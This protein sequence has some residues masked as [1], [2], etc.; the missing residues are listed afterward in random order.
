MT[1]KK[2]SWIELALQWQG[3]VAPKVL[4]G[5]L[6]CGG[7]GFFVSI[8]DYFGLPIAWPG[9]EVVISNVSYNLVLGLLLVFRTNTAYERFWE[10]RKAWATFTANI[11]NLGYLMWAAITEVEPT[12]R[13]TKVLTLRLLST[14]AFAAKLHLQRQPI[15][16]ESARLTSNQ[17]LKLKTVNGPPLQLAVWIGDYFQQQHQRNLLTT[18]QLTMMNDLVNGLLE[19]LTTCERILET[20]IPLAYAIYLK[21]LLLIY[22]FSL[23]FQVGNSLH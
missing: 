12:D 14:W 18:N 3:S 15:E 17:L 8:A 2:S 13:E 7:L 19:A 23:P 11:R 21:R 16:S 9:L 10:G 1:V 20:P 5:A 22:C 6:L 4:P